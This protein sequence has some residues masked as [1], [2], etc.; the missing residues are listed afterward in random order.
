ML[1]QARV[2]FEPDVSTIA[3]SV[4][5]MEK[6]LRLLT[7]KRDAKAQEVEIRRL[8]AEIASLQ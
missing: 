7:L 6:E 3:E 8:E 2:D 1:A 5:Q 4:A